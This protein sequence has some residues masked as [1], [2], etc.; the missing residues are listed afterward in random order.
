LRVAG[1]R[2]GQWIKIENFGLKINSLQDTYTVTTGLTWQ[3]YFRFVLYNLVKTKAIRV[4]FSFVT[5]IAVL[6]GVLKIVVPGKNGV[7]LPEAL[8]PVIFAPLVVCLF[9]AGLGLLSALYVSKYKAGLIKGI[10]Y[11]FTHWGMEKTG[12]ASNASIPWR[13]FTR[14]KETKHYFLLY[15]YENNVETFEII[16]K[17]KFTSLAE[18]DEFKQF[19]QQNIPPRRSFRGNTNGR[20]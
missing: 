18:R 2:C 6:D 1:Q 14:L 11:K 17:E 9:F 10:T 19:I 4:I 20:R 7:N 16:Q 3:Q 5:C 12:P 15:G 8:A 13:N